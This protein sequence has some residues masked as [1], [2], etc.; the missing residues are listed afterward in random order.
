MA[1]VVGFGALLNLESVVTTGGKIV[2]RCPGVAVATRSGQLSDSVESSTV[3]LA[4]N[5]GIGLAG[6]STLPGD[7]HWLASLNSGWRAGELNSLGDGHGGESSDDE[8]LIELHYL[9]LFSCF[10]CSVIFE[11]MGVKV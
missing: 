3:S 7:C 4:K 8:R 11:E 6:I 2:G 10:L 1:R 9:V 5:D